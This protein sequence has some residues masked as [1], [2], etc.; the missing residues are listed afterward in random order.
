MASVRYRW[1]AQD[2]GAGE[3]AT[4]DVIGDVVPEPAAPER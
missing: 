2:G 4:R 1:K 3:T